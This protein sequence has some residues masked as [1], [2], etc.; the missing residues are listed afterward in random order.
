[1]IVKTILQD[2]MTRICMGN[3]FDETAMLLP[4]VLVCPTTGCSMGDGGA[5][6][7]TPPL[8]EKIAMQLMDYHR[9]DVHGQQIGGGGEEVW[10]VGVRKLFMMLGGLGKAHITMRCRTQYSEEDAVRRSSNPSSSTGTNTPS[11]TMEWMLGS[12]DNSC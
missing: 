9:A 3:K 4:T 7:R 10:M 11:T 6:W 2:H 5:R 1:M 8:T 12:C